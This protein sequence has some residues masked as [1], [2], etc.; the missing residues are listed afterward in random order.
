M[1]WAC[2]VKLKLNLFLKFDS[3]VNHADADTTF[4]SSGNIVFKIH[5]KHL[6]GFFWNQILGDSR[7]YFIDN[8]VDFEKL[9]KL[10]DHPVKDS[11]CC[12]SLTTTIFNRYGYGSNY[13]SSRGQA[14]VICGTLVFIF[15][16]GLENFNLIC[17]FI[18]SR[19]ML[20]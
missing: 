2:S 18:H 14:R 19:H 16:P 20:K 12:P 10:E 9:N 1:L 8:H 4:K 11:V 3:S 7:K 5:S 6:G 17:N 15:Q 13:G